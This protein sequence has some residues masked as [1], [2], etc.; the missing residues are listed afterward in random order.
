MQTNSPRTILS[1]GTALALSL[2]MTG[3]TP[4][5]STYDDFGGNSIDS[6]RWTLFGEM[7]RASQS[8][9]FL[10][11]RGAGSK[12]DIDLLAVDALRGDFEI[13]LDF[14]RFRA[15]STANEPG[16]SLT[17]VDAIT[18]PNQG[19]V[20][21]I[22]IEATARGHSFFGCA[23]L[24]GRSLGEA[25]VP[26]R[27]SAG[28]LR[29]TRA[30]GKI[31][32]S[33]QEKGNNTWITLR[34]WTDFFKTNTVRFLVSS[35]AGTADAADVSCDK[36]WIRGKR[37]SGSPAYGKRCANLGFAPTNLPKIGTT[38]GLLTA[39][40]GSFARA[41]FAIILGERPLA[42]DLTGAGAPGCFLHTPLTILL[43]GGALDA[44]G[45]GILALPIP[46][47]NALVGARFYTQA[48]ATTAKNSMGLAWS[49]GAT[50]GLTR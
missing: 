6:T 50:S 36:I 2:A 8:G 29:L 22:A 43:V 44:E 9:G 13:I 30:A 23:E 25:S 41:G 35:L 40:D 39:G 21:S 32:V 18:D 24:G 37:I 4:A 42:I 49:V 14:E 20:V 1:L 33:A 27:A 15:R 28:K 10:L 19:G 45:L 46:A 16:L 48:V 26:T 12:R 17:A 34:T 38:L 7:G 5:Q 47:S 3:V 31:S 11:L